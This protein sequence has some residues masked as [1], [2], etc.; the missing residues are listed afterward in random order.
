MK[1]TSLPLAILLIFYVSAYCQTEPVTRVL[2]KTQSSSV[3]TGKTIE[4]IKL[5]TIKTS[6]IPGLEIPEIKPGEKIISHTG[7]SLVYNEKHE[8]ASWVAYE[9]TRAE[10]KSVVAR[11]NNF[12]T[13]PK[14]ETG[15]ADDNDYIGSGY[16][17]GHLASA[18]DMCWSSTAMSESFYYSNMS[19]QK[20]GF[21]RGIW[22]KL[23]VQ[24]RKWAVENNS[25]YIVTGPVLTSGLPSI[26]PDKVSV[27]KY[28]YK[29]ILDY[30]EPDI[31]GIGFV[32]PNASSS[33]PLQSFAMTIDSV[34]KITGINFYTALPDNQENLIESTLCIKCWSWPGEK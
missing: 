13:D 19:P 23:E 1:K 22:K 31:K 29:V 17:K 33:Q 14:V 12:I 25:V 3:N 20:K 16:D 11:K 30:T 4:D 28:Y 24:V 21:N 26:G 10:T 32:I 6:R 2:Q 7:Y 34:E 8:Q 5:N 18:A 9:L 15:T 27:P